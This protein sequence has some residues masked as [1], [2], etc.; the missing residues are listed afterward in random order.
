MIK[1]RF[2]TTLT[3]SSDHKRSLHGWQNSSGRLCLG[4]GLGRATLERR[5]AVPCNVPGQAI[6]LR[7]LLP[8]MPANGKSIEAMIRLL[9]LTVPGTNKLV[10]SSRMTRQP[11]ILSSPVL[12][13]QQELQDALRA[14]KQRKA[15][16]RGMA[17]AAV[18]KAL[19]SPLSHYLSEV[20]GAMWQ[21]GRLRI[22]AI[23][24]QSDLHFLPKPQKTTK[25]PQDLRP[26]ALQS[27]LPRRL[28][29]S[30]STAYLSPF[31]RLCV[32][33][34]NM[35]IRPIAAHRRALPE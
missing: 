5:A 33:S 9:H 12:L 19:A 7:E 15:V 8:A 34:L 1:Q 29:Q 35:P 14:L 26:I 2:P 10:S 25:R 30:S 27:A 24:T 13:S 20:L 31:W 32:G 17:P 6:P 4:V 21:P 18:W 3:N 28:L 16:A 22:P 23:W 11:A